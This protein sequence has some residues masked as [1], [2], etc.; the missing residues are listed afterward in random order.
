MHKP[1]KKPFQVEGDEA[2]YQ[3]LAT[4]HREALAKA[5]LAGDLSAGRAM[6][7]HAMTAARNALLRAGEADKIAL[8]F[9]A[10]GLEQFLIH[11]IELARALCIQSEGGRPSQSE[12]A[13]GLAQQL[14]WNKV[15]AALDDATANGARI[16][17]EQARQKVAGSLGISMSKVKQADLAIERLRR[18]A[19]YSQRDK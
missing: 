10:D 17:I 15:T 19:G 5:A 11:E 4:P 16:T 18:G 12:F 1:S 7:Q 13:K 9:L 3:R 2:R 8:K 14:I 6:L